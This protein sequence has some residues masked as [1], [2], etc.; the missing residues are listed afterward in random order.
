MLGRVNRVRLSGTQRTEAHQAPLSVGFSRQ[1]YWSGLPFPP[2]GD[3]PDPGTELV[4]LASPA[5]AGGF[6][7][8][9][10]TWVWEVSGG[11]LVCSG[12]SCGPEGMPHGG[13]RVREAQREAR[14]RPP[15]GSCPSRVRSGLCRGS[16]FYSRLRNE[17]GFPHKSSPERDSPSSWGWGPRAAP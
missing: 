1:A 15:A 7:A 5:L 13:T 17:A 10:A 12:H 9:S 11:S 14:L 8:A 16:T 2:P 6:F 4:S 3:P